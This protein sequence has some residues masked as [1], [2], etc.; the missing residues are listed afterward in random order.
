LI[1]LK[2]AKFTLWISQLVQVQCLEAKLELWVH[3]LAVAAVAVVQEAVVL[4]GWNAIERIKQTIDDLGILI[5]V[6]LKNKG[7]I[8]I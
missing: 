4:T 6:L 8:F 5:H 7:A 1:Q 2:T 3:V